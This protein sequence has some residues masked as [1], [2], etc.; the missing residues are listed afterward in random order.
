[1]DTKKSP[2]K[3]S[4]EP[5]EST[6]ESIPANQ[7]VLPIPRKTSF[8]SI[9]LIVLLSL[10]IG[11]FGMYAFLNRANIFSSISLQPRVTPAQESDMNTY[12]DEEAG[13]S[14]QYPKTLL[15]N[16]ESKGAAHMV[17]YAGSETIDDIKEQPF[18]SREI[19]LEEKEALAKGTLPNTA[20]WS[21]E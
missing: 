7:Q 18:M 6:K 20:D 13:F 5:L 21:I 15:L 8:L 17:L 10:A 16:A 14:F 12:T 1:M 2:T 9:F 11:G 19:A 4:T 3:A